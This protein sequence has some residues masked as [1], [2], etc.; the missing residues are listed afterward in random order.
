[1]RGQ[2]RAAE[3]LAEVQNSV[4]AT[5]KSSCRRGLLACGHCDTH[6]VDIAFRI[7]R[8][9]VKTSARFFVP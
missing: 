3:V 1:M 5:R 9:R 8:E 6:A 7:V 4:R 2:G